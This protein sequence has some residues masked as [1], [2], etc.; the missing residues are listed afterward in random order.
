MGFR[1][2]TFLLCSVV[3]TIGAAAP[4]DVDEIVR[5]H[6]SA[7]GG[8]ARWEHVDSL[9][10][11]GS[12]TFGSFTWVWKRPDK[13]RTD[14]RDEHGTG[15]TLVTAFDGHTGWTSNP[16]TD[17]LPRK[18]GIAELQRWQSGLAIRSDLLDL[19]APDATLSLLGQEK[20]NGRDAYK[21]SLLR[22]GRDE[23]LLWIDTESYLLVQ[24]A[25]A[26]VAPWGELRTVATPLRDYRNVNGVMI[27]HAIGDTRLTTEVNAAIDD[28]LFRPPQ[29]LR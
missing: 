8:V 15:R 6:V 9:L 19:P 21:L 7:I 16:F 4:P 25:R 28:A 13:V 24:R 10:V 20:V 2:A 22:D 17:G 11:R 29:T 14:E 18:L 23:V 26:V 1:C 5:R 3:A 12:G 27:P